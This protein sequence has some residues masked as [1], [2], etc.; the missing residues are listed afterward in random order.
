MVRAESPRTS[1]W[2]GVGETGQGGSRD[3]GSVAS[4]LAHQEQRAASPALPAPRLRP[5]PQ[6]PEPVL[7]AIRPPPFSPNRPHPSAPIST[8]DL[9][10]LPLVIALLSPAYRK[11]QSPRPPLVY[12]RSPYLSFL[13]M[14]CSRALQPR[15]LDP[16]AAYAG[17]R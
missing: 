5:L 11:T 10:P 14:L 15:G 4:P 12:H 9:S 1:V 2:K 6:L 16:S 13:A 7:A 8:L 3:P 17:G